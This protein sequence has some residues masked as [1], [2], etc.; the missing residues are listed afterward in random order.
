[1]FGLHKSKK[2]NPSHQPDLIRL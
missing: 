2:S 1:V